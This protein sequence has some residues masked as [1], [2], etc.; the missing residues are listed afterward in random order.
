MLIGRAYRQKIPLALTLFAASAAGA[1]AGGFGMPWRHVIEGSMFSLYGVLVM[2]TGL[3]LLQV[4]RESGNLEAIAR[5]VVTA[6]R[7][8]PVPLFLLLVLMLYVPGMITGLGAAGMSGAGAVVAAILQAAGVPRPKT[9]IIL[10]V[11]AA[12]G[13]AAPP[14]NLPAMIIAGSLNMPLDG[15]SPFLLPLTAPPGIFAIF[16]LGRKHFRALTLRE[17]AKLLPRPQRRFA[18]EPYVPILIVAILFGLTSAFPQRLPAPGLPLIFMIGALAGLFTGKGANIFMAA[19]RCLGGRAL[20]VA[21]VFFVLGG[22]MQVMTLTGVK[23]LLAMSALELAAISPVLPC[24]ALVV[25]I[26]LLGGV[27]TPLGAAAVLG[28]PFAVAIMAIPPGSA[29]LAVACLSVL[30]VL[31]RIAPPARQASPL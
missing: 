9:G 17:I 21:A 27:I 13:A 1:L 30:C 25:C 10:G 24:A 5:D 11:A 14:V 8:R 23:G 28:A 3:I 15:L 19:S 18:L 26:P 7:A 2:F 29:A 31:G 12:M 6:F 20:G 22:V 4:M 16:F